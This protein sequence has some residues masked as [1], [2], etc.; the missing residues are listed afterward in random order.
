[1]ISDDGLAAIFNGANEAAVAA[2]LERKIAFGR[3]VALVDEAL[4]AVDVTR[5]DSLEAID[6]ADRQAR[7]FVNDHLEP[8]VVVNNVGSRSPAGT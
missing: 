5:A 1:M 8:K 6:Q 4:S 3:I 2:F 7:A